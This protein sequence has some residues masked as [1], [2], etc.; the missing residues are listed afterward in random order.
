MLGPLAST[1][2]IICLAP[3]ETDRTSRVTLSMQKRSGS[4][5]PDTS[6][7]PRPTVAS[8]TSWE[9]SPVRGSAV[10]I[11]PERVAGTMSWMTTAM[12]ILSIR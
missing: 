6:G 4:I 1:S 9:R 12:E 5:S 3:T 10:I 8:T 2:A 7:S 11:T